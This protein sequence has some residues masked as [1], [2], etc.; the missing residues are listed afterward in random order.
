M[1]GGFEF[2]S[3]FAG[4]DKAWEPVG[5][6]LGEHRRRMKEEGP[7]RS[8]P[9]VCLTL[10]V[11]RLNAEL[12][13]QSFKAQQSPSQQHR[14]QSP[15]GNGLRHS[16]ERVYRE[17]V[18]PMVIQPDPAPGIVAP[19]RRP[20]AQVQ[21]VAGTVECKHQSKTIHLRRGRCIDQVVVRIA[22]VRARTVASDRVAPGH[23][24]NPMIAPPAVEKGT[25]MFI[26]PVMFSTRSTPA[27]SLMAVI[28]PLPETPLPLTVHDRVSAKAP[29][30]HNRPAASEKTSTFNFA[31][32]LMGDPPTSQANSQILKTTVGRGTSRAIR[33]SDFMKTSQLHRALRKPHLSS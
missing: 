19:R 31:N 7:D 20:R 26:Y 10:G 16:R 1:E 14:C 8:G 23:V 11:K 2:S 4:F 3:S 27:P 21:E 12:A 5:S 33:H 15:V 30:A 9:F 24:E 22:A 17:S 18:A 32:C 29:V 28:V 13:P 6:P 25:V